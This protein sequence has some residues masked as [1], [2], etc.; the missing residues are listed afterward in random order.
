MFLKIT[1]SGT[2][3]YLQLVE[4][5][6]DE[7]GK[8]RHRTLVTLG[9]L[10]QLT[11]SLDSVI[12]GLLKVTGRPNF[13]DAALPAVEFESARALGN[14]WALNELWESLGFGELRRVFRKT[15]HSIDVEALIRVMV[16]NRLCDP[17]SKLGVLRWLDTV[18]M[19]GVE[20]ETIT[21]QHLLRSMDALVDHQADVD[22]VVANLLR[23]LIDQELSVVFYDMTTIRTEGLATVDGDVR[24]YGMAKEGL[25]ARQ[26]MLG[27]VQTG[28]GLPIYHEVFAGNTAESPTLLPTLKTVLERFPSISRVVL[29]ADRGL[30]S[31]DNLEAL[32]EIRLESGKPLEF[33]LAV[34]GRRYSEFAD[35]LRDFQRQCEAAEQEIVD[36]LPWRGLRLIVA[37]HPE[38]ARQAQTLRRERIET[39]ETQANTW[40]GKLDAQDAGVKARGK[41]LSD[42]GAKARLYHAVKDARLAN[43]I[44]VDL[45][46]ER[47]AY[48]IDHDA[49]ALAELM[50]GKLLLVTN[51]PDLSPQ[52]VVDRYKSLADIERGFR[53]LKSE[54]E[55]G[56]VFHRLPERIKAHA[57]ICFIAL[58]LYRV[59]RQRLSS[60]DAPLSPERALEE[61]Q[62]LQR[63]QIRINQADRPVTGISRLSETQDRVFAA[64]RLKKPTQ[65]QQLSLL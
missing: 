37:H 20:V 33:V 14:V 24:Q 47:F 9:R 15:R 8:A 42:S 34:P 54:I 3:Q 39:L 1:R 64:L 55:I 49:L 5:F 63:H 28:D 22:A 19:P 53:V 48:E 40:V 43:I 26:V 27:V 29:V 17:E 51:T 60:A 10:D 45:K 58:I 38:L 16:F 32:S 50:D 2:R 18:A 56:P 62:K 46:N 36:E 41:K 7:A 65:P 11:D 4:A 25:I 61:L 12:S 13:L 57:A 59:M 31:L 21:H 52:G 35:L 6:R 30:L 23:P 44:R